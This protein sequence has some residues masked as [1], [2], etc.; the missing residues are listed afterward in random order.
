MGFS[1]A[2]ID[3]NNRIIKWLYEQNVR[4]VVVSNN[5]NNI[6]QPYTIWDLRKIAEGLYR[7]HETIDEVFMLVMLIA[8]FY[9]EKLQ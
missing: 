7:S 5:N 6:G 4:N 8:I 1:K 3:I 2:F 9:Q